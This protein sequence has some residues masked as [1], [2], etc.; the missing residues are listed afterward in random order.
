MFLNFDMRYQ[1]NNNV[2]L[3]IAMKNVLESK[4]ITF[5]LSPEIPRSI[6]FD[7]GYNF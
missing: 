7:I 3:G 6:A 1:L 4:A 2:S 5:P